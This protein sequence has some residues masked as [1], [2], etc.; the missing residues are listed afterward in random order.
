MSSV[1]FQHE[2]IDWNSVTVLSALRTSF[3]QMTLTEFGKFIEFIDN[4]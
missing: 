3:S 1:F 2:V 4:F